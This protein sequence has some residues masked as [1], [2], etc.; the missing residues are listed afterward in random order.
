VRQGAG[1][2]DGLRV[3]AVLQEG[4]RRVPD[5][6]DDGLGEFCDA[7]QDDRH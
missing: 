4:D 6:R 3:L 1:E 5:V 2:H 7:F